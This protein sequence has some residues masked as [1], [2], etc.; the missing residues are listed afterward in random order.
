MMTEY[1]MG[2]LSFLNHIPVLLLDAAFIYGATYID[3][4]GFVWILITSVVLLATIIAIS[5]TSSKVYMLSDDALKVRLGKKIVREY[6]L[7][8]I[9]TI[10]ERKRSMEIGIAYKNK[11][12]TVYIGWYISKYKKMKIQLIENIQKLDNYDRIIFVD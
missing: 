3:F 4:Y 6:E 2:V 1:K 5:L 11:I 8:S 7:S 10:K 9:K 12:K